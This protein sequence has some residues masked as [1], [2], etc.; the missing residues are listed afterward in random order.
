[1]DCSDAVALRVAKFVNDCSS[2]RCDDQFLAQKVDINV[3]LSQ[4]SRIDYILSSV[5]NDITYFEV[6]DPDVNFSDHLPLVCDVSVFVPDRVHA[7]NSQ[8]RATPYYVG[9][10]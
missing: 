7:A 1:M 3:S 4:L 2:Y 5:I 9:T 6:L 8:S 10:S